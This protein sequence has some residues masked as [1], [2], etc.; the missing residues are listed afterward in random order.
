MTG[1]DARRHAEGMSSSS[2]DTRPSDVVGWGTSAPPTDAPGSRPGAHPARGWALTRKVVLV[3]VL[4]CGVLG[5]AG[6]MVLVVAD[7]TET[8]DMWHGLM[9]AIGAAVGVPSLVAA[10]LAVLA[11]RAMR[12]SGPEGGR[13]PTCLLGGGLLLPGLMAPGL[14]V[15]LVPG[16]LGALLLATVVVEGRSGS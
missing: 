5:V 15:L 11:L 14:P 6:G 16:L 2:H 8:D 10:V 12:R 4:V 3:L 9:A 1:Y 13:V 7:L